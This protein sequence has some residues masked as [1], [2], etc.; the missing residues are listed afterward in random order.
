MN[1]Y[2]RP[3]RAS[4]FMPSFATFFL[5]WSST[6]AVSVF[7]LPVQ[8]TWADERR[9]ASTNAR[10]R[11]V[12][13]EKADQVFPRNWAFAMSSTS[14]RHPPLPLQQWVTESITITS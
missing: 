10:H 6:W 7:D 13:T 14:S 2:S 11:G 12:I 8:I 3:S 9:I 4:S 1:S 5:P